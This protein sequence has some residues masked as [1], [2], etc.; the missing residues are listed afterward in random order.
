[1]ASGTANPRRRSRHCRRRPSRWRSWRRAPRRPGAPPTLRPRARRRVWQLRDGQARRLPVG[2]DLGLQRDLQRDLDGRR[3]GAYIG[4]V[5]LGAA[6][7]PSRSDHPPRPRFSIPPSGPGRSHH[8][9]LNRSP[10]PGFAKAPVRARRW[11]AHARRRRAALSGRVT[12]NARRDRTSIASPF[13]F[14]VA[15]TVAGLL[16]S[17]AASDPTKPARPPCDE[18][19]GPGL[20][21]SD[22]G[23]PAHMRST[24]PRCRHA[25]APERAPVERPHGTTRAGGVPSHSQGGV[26]HEDLG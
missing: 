12:V 6:Q 20:P 23:A 21:V 13:G 5:G 26:P 2:V 15:Q 14:V 8:T 24:A 3:C 17:R 9:S 25:T 7:H 19:R 10:R 22:V 18:P 1:M 11:L 16:G 4:S